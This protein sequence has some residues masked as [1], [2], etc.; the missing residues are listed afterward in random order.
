MMEPRHRT[1]A[2]ILGFPRSGTTLLAR[3][4]DAHP[5]ISAPPETGLWSAA[6][7]FLTELAEVEGPP[8]GVLTGM[9]FAG[10][11]PEET[12]AAV[13]DLVFALQD[14]AAG[15]KPATVTLDKT[16]TD[17]F[18]LETLEPVLAG[19]VRCLC[20]VRN[21][22][23]VVASNIDLART[24]GAWLPELHARMAGANGDHLALA[25]IWAERQTALDGFATR[26]PDGCLILRYEDLLGDPD[27]QLTRVLAFLGLAGDPRMLLAGAFSDRARIGLGDFRID[28]TQ[29]LRPADPAG[30]RKRLP[31]AA[32]A[33]ML[34]VLAPL[35]AVHGYDVPKLPAMP[36]RM[37]AIRQFEFA[38]RLK[39]QA[40]EPKPG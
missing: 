4:L 27:A 29:G 33:R 39:R 19:Q 37:T 1:R 28:A 8:Y 15:D 32:A 6:G 40:G 21:P 10:V 5:A 17:I 35:M 26:H 12:A 25:R 22:F 30:W 11:P 3:L 23:E 14:R 16:G 31:R 34:P 18:H 7:R 9:A 13:R 2:V 20:L 36:D 24:L 38:A